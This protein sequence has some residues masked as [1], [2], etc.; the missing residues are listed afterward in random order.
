MAA[1]APWTEYGSNVF[2]AT[3]SVFSQCVSAL[4]LD[5]HFR[6]RRFQRVFGGLLESCSSL[7][8]VGHLLC[9]GGVS[10]DATVPP[11]TAPRCTGVIP[12]PNATVQAL[13]P[14]C[15]AGLIQLAADWG[16]PLN[17]NRN[18]LTTVNTL[19]R[20]YITPT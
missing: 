18:Q 20:L 5:M 3:I 17:E 15:L 19:F 1:P 2:A 9:N 10:A 14:E 8:E 4:A 16:N 11:S 13:H 7:W 6:P 12:Q